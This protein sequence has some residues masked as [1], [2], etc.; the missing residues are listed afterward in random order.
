MAAFCARERP[1]DRGRP[2]PCLRARLK[3]H[4][5]RFARAM[6]LLAMLLQNGQHIALKG[7]FCGS[8]ANRPHYGF[9]TLV[10]LPRVPVNSWVGIKQLYSILFFMTDPTDLGDTWLSLRIEVDGIAWY[11]AGLPAWGGLDVD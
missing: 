7:K 5:P 8:V 10:Y 2:R 6:A 3:R 1:L 9:R 4:R 11:A